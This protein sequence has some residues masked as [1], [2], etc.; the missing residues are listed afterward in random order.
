MIGPMQI[1]FGTIMLGALVSVWGASALFTSLRNVRRKDVLLAS[2]GGLALLW[3]ALLLSGMPAVQAMFGSPGLTWNYLQAVIAYLLPIPFAAYLV[4]LFGTGWKGVYTW[5]LRA[6]VVLSLVAVLFDAALEKPFSAVPAERALGAV[7]GLALLV[8]ASRSGVNLAGQKWILAAGFL[9]FAVAALGEIAGGETFL[10]AGV[11]ETG[12]GL[13]CVV[14]A[15]GYVAV[16]RSLD[17][18]RRT[19]RREQEME[20]ARQI[21]FT[22]VPQEISATRNLRIAQRYVPAQSIQG[23]FFDIAVAGDSRVCVLV[24]DVAARGVPAAGVASILKAVFATQVASVTDPAVILNLMNRIL[25]D[26]TEKKSASAGCMMID[27]VSGVMA[28]AGAGHTPLIVWRKREKKCEEFGGGEVVL[29]PVADAQYGSSFVTL[30]QG[31]RVVAYSKGA[32]DVLDKRGSL[33]GEKRL[34]DLIAANEAL[35]VEQFAEKVTQ[36]ILAWAGMNEGGSLPDDI[37][38]IVVDMLSKEKPSRG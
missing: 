23:N 2:F 33:F 30:K 27:A 36:A 34:R 12:L 31:D 22:I 26:R 35:S 28:Y 5:V 37:T 15:L 3:G 24:G 19:L 8:T 16:R 13:S 7:W 18:A 21:H 10:P 1:E 17:V 38:L 11:S 20:A 6:A 32:V 4:G 25:A 14:F 9:V 29:G